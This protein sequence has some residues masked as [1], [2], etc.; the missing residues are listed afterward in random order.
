MLSR[1]EGKENMIGK[2]FKMGSMVALLLVAAWLL[3]E[4]IPA[5]ALAPAGAL[6]ASRSE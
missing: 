2:W 6:E 1:T 4:P 3:P 5:D